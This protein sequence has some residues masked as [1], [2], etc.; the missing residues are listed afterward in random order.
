MSSMAVSQGRQSGEAQPCQL[1]K[2][3]RNLDLTIELAGETA[4]LVAGTAGDHPGVQV[5][6]QGVMQTPT[7]AEFQTWL[8]K[9]VAERRIP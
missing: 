5:L 1:G 3:S 6:L 7:A 4:R 2:D 8:E 9:A